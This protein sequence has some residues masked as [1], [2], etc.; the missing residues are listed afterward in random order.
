M[1]G[2]LVPIQFGIQTAETRSGA[3]GLERLRNWYP[4][5]TP[6]RA[7]GPVALLPT[8][9]LK[10]WDTVGNGPVRGMRAVGGDLYVVSDESL[11]AVDNVPTAIEI[12]TVADNGHCHMTDNGTHVA[13]CAHTKAY[14]ANRTEI[15]ELPESNL[16]GA[17]Y[18]DGQAFFTKA[19]TQ[20]LW[21]GDVDDMTSINAL[22]YTSV[23]ALTGNVQGCVSDHREIYAFTTQACGVYK[24]YG[25]S[26]FP[27]E[28]VAHFE[29]GCGAP[30]SIAKD[31]NT[32]FW[33]GNDLTVYKA[34]GYEPIPI[35]PPW[36]ERLIQD[37]NDPTTA[38]AFTYEQN[39]RKFYCL[40]FSELT[41][42]YDLTTNMWHDRKSHLLE[43]WRAGKHAYFDGKHLVGDIVNGNIY[44]LDL[45]TYDDNGDTI[46]RE[47]V[48]PPLFARGNRAVMHELYLDFETGVGLTSGTGSDPQVMLDWTEDYGATWSNEVWADLGQIGERTHRVTFN[49]LGSYRQRT[50]RI[51]ISD[52]VETILVG[53][54]A[55]IEERNS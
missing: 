49:R 46:R 2:R 43:N 1:A 5:Q 50:L 14:A 55:R 20:E 41:L 12:G 40:L 39:G 19:G 24:N 11:W 32:V 54:Y 27:L 23:D 33:L 45:D 3:I 34:R 18:Q 47:A 44:E 15:L 13:I 38:W 51:A 7:K 22:A 35:S 4:A 37:I 48:S 36:V 53:A 8:P 29:R 21:A 9:G 28:R 31:D 6:S 30:G 16:N 10:L 25:Y 42:V 17:T 52:P 26:P